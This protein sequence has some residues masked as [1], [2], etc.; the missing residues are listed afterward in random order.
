M[1]CYQCQETA[2]GTGCIIKGVCGKSEDVSNLL[3]LLIYTS[4]GISICCE[5]AEIEDAEVN[6]FV[7]DALFTSITNVNF[8][9]YVISEKL[10]KV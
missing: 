7:V 9:K 3:D 10:K 8:D 2:K 1:F 4:K 6:D 5:N